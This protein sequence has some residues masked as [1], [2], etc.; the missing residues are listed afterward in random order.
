MW[1]HH[2]VTATGLIIH[3]RVQQEKL[4][5]SKKNC[6]AILTEVWAT[7]NQWERSMQCRAARHIFGQLQAMSRK[8]RQPQATGKNSRATPKKDSGSPE[9]CLDC[10][11][12][13]R[14]SPA[15]KKP[16]AT[17]SNWAAS[18]NSGQ[19]VRATCLDYWKI[20]LSCY[21]SNGKKQS[22]KE[23]GAGSSEV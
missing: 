19:Q 8:S 16:R 9:K 7:P 4:P 3:C 18:L 22:G 12:R 10:S 2:I 17:S 21:A 1:T 20:V 13:L 6:R 11:R 5:S 15:N 14:A 23:Q